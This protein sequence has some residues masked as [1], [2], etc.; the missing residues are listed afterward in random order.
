MS[1]AVRIPVKPAYFIHHFQN[2]LE[3]KESSIHGR[4][5]FAKRAFQQG[6]VV[7]IMR[8]MIMHEA[9]YPAFVTEFPDLDATICRTSGEYM[10][11]DEKFYE[12]ELDNFINHASAPNVLFHCGSIFAL[13]DIASGEEITTNYQYILTPNEQLA[14]PSGEV[15]QGMD[16]RTSMRATTE[17]LLKIL[18]G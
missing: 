2:D 13:R 1:L 16:A 3:V 7:I 9:N 12:T 8:G 5:L 15:V 18:A 6:E 4:G 11:F 10:L 17:T 14:L